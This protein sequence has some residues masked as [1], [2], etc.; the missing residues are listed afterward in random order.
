M[1]PIA[2]RVVYWRPVESVNLARPHR[3]IRA[4]L[5]AMER[6]PMTGRIEEQAYL[7]AAIADPLQA[8]VLVAG[9][10]GVG[11]TRLLREVTEGQTDNRIEFV[12]ATESARPLPFGAFA[13][14]LPEDLGSID[15]VDLL[16]VIGRH[17][18]RR[19]EGKPL[20]L[21]V[22]DMHLLDAFAGMWLDADLAFDAIEQHKLRMA[23]YREAERERKA[24]ERGEFKLNFDGDKAPDTLA[25]MFPDE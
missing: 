24:E 11:K 22:D 1:A 16:A 3:G 14:L 19:A 17:L 15:R 2:H 10:A 12:T 4:R 20:I 6:W 21:A 9:G 25:G 13:H 8:G 23:T 7:K 18:V 5:L